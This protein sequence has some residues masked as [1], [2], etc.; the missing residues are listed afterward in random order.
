MRHFDDTFWLDTWWDTGWG[1]LMIHFEDTFWWVILMQ[2]FDETFWWDIFIG[3]FDDW[4]WLEICPK[5]DEISHKITELYDWTFQFYSKCLALIT[6][7]L[8]G[9]FWPWDCNWPMLFNTVFLLWR[10]EG[11]TVKYSHKGNP[12]GSGYILP[13]ILT[14][15]IIQTFSV[16][17]SYTSSNVLPGR[18]ILEELI[19]CIGVAAGAIF[20]ILPIRWS[21]TGPYRPSR[22][23]CWGS[24]KKYIWS[25]DFLEIEYDVY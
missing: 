14:W 18:A 22:N 1:I 17:K 3:H 23:F 11:Y 20:P 24:T 5:Y 8:F 16:S 9:L 21:N 25:E 6:L 4:K 15:V 12:E 7:S 13:Y 19:L 10:E 2:H